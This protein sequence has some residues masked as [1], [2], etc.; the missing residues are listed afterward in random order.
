MREARRICKNSTERSYCFDYAFYKCINYYLLCIVEKI[1]P[2][3]FKTVARE[4]SDNQHTKEEENSLI[5][6]IYKFYINPI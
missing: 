2:L 1:T 3:D 5:K 4:K 6:K